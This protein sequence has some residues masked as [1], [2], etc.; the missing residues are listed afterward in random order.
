[1][2]KMM[3]TCAP[4]LYICAARYESISSPGYFFFVIL[5][6]VSLVLSKV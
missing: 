5:K 6:M 4:R 3:T 2:L 1:M